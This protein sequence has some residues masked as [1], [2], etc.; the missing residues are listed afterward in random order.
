[1]F[2]GADVDRPWR[3]RC[4]SD[5]PDRADVDAVEDRDPGPPGIVGAPDAAVHGAEVEAYRIHRIAR[6]REDPPAAEGTD[7][8]PLEVLEQLRV[9]RRR[10]RWRGQRDRR[11]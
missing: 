10:L 7:R 1:G 2:A 4:D 3:R 6:D 9:Y 5:R 11:A 8:A